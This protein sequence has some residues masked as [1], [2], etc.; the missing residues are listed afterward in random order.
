MTK[1]PQDI[2]LKPIVTEKSS[3]DSAAGKYSF[4]VDERATKTEIRMAIEKLFDVKVVS[5][6]TV[7]YDGKVKRQRAVAGLTPSWKKAVV[8]IAT[9]AKD[10]TYLTKGGKAAKIPAKYKTSIEEFGFG[11]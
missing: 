2:I 8:T 10:V 11:Q 1:A 3:L 9:E 6:N 4:K 7:R 5:V